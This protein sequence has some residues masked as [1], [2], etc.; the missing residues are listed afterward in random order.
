M[1]KITFILFL[2]TLLLNSCNELEN[3]NLV[4]DKVNSEIDN[5]F[6]LNEGNLLKDVNTYDSEGFINALIEIPTGTREKWEVSKKT[7]QLELNTKKGKPRKIEYLPYPVNYGMI[8][9]TLLPKEEGG[10]GDPLDIIVIGD[11]IPKGTV[12]PCRILGVLKLLDKGEQ[13]DKLIAI[14]AESQY[15]DVNN[16]QELDSAKND[17]TKLIE[18]WFTNYKGP[19][20]MVFQGYGDVSEA[21][22]LLELSIVKN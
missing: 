6:N 1:F 8:P 9:N 20:K 18:I 11:P 17:L 15:Y 22:H 21:M 13:D 7:G 19:G 5:S 2:G 14:R 10:D 4:K 12:V 3:N 16:I